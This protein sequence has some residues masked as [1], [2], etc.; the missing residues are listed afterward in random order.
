[1]NVEGDCEFSCFCE[2]LIPT[3]LLIPK[4]RTPRCS[5]ET[6][7][8]MLTDMSLVLGSVCLSVSHAHPHSTRSIKDLIFQSKNLLMYF[9]QTNEKLT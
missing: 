7:G 5:S 6:Q 9:S 3:K 4:G 2:A 8:M 1:M